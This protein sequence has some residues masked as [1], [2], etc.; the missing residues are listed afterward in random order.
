MVFLAE[1]RKN[2]KNEE[3][4][5]VQEFPVRAPN[6][7]FILVPFFISFSNWKYTLR[8]Y[9]SKDCSDLIESARKTNTLKVSLLTKKRTCSLHTSSLKSQG[10]KQMKDCVVERG[11]SVAPLSVRILALFYRIIP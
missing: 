5:H 9:I 6:E 10:C 3:N 8:Y 4:V 2:T 11:H 7:A 1:A